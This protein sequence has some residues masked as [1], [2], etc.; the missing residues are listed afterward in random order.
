MTGKK[1]RTTRR[2][3]REYL[4]QFQLAGEVYKVIDHFF[5]ELICKLKEISDP[6]NQSYIKYQNHV[7]LMMRILSSILYINSMR[8]ATEE[9]NSETAIENLGYICGEKLE[10]APYW[11][12]INNYLKKIDPSELQGIIQELVKRLIRSKA[13]NEGRIRGKYWHIIIDGTQLHSSKKKLDGGVC[14]VHNKGKAEE[15]TEYYW[16]VLEAKLVL[17]PKI[18]VSIMSEFVENTEYKG[19]QDCEL[20]AAKRLMERLKKEFPRLPICLCA[21]SLYACEPFFKQCEENGWKYLLNF[22]EGSI[23]SMVTEY[24]ALRQIENNRVTVTKDGEQEWYD[25]VKNIEYKGHLLHFIEYGGSI[26]SDSS[27]LLTNLP[28]CKRSVA[29]TV[30]TARRR[31]KIENEGFNNQKNHGYYLE[32]VFCFQNWAMKNHYFLI[33]IGHMISQIMEAWDLLWKKAGLNLALKHQRI[34]ESWKNDRLTL[35]RPDLTPAFQIR[36]C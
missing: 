10:E 27:Y 36:F 35:I 26:R 34:L 29:K 1:K 21:D 30:Q 23:P 33:Q 11:E 15:Y 13:F 8:R 18:V 31:W 19:K 24:E 20:Q 32:H 22:R 16:Y 2:E 6:R 3:R 25:F 17:H 28:L 12:T 9:F 7:L 5:P 14:R 4:K